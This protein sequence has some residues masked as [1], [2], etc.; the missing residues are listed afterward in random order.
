MS[1]LHKVILLLCMSDI[2]DRVGCL[3]EGMLTMTCAWV[4]YKESVGCDGVA[5]S[6]L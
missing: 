5:G 2:L 3:R 1:A 4:V 6:N